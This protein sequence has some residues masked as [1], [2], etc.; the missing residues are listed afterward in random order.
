[1]MEALLFTLAVALFVF[2]RWG[3]RNA[4]MLVPT[5][6]SEEGQWRKE[7]SVRRGGIAFQIVAVLWILLT[8]FNVIWMK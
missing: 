7:R 3:Q 6:L 4:A 2:G 5:A 1:M 8:A